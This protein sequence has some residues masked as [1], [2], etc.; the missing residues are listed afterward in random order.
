VNGPKRTEIEAEFERLLSGLCDGTLDDAGR[1]EL[2]RR[3]SQSAADRRTYIEYLDLHAALGRDPVGAA[4]GFE[5]TNGAS[6]PIRFVKASR[7]RFIR[8]VAGLAASAALVALAA[9]A[10]RSLDPATPG[11]E[12]ATESREAT[13]RVSA[14]A[15]LHEIVGE[16]SVQRPTGESVVACDG[17]T[18][19]AGQ[20][21][22][23][24]SDDGFVALGFADGTRLELNGE[25]QLRLA[26]DGRS[27]VLSSGVLRGSVTGGRAGSQMVVSTPQAEIHVSQDTCFSVSAPSA[28]TTEVET[29]SGSVRMVRVADGR[30]AEVPAGSFA[31]A[32]SGEAT[33]SVRPR[34][35]VVNRPLRQL[36][37][38]RARAL[39]FSGDGR[40]LT[41]ASTQ[42]RVVLVL[43]TGAALFPVAEFPESSE[44]VSVSADGSRVMFVGR[45]KRVRRYDMR[46]GAELP[47]IDPASSAN[48]AWAMSG[49]GSVIAAGHCVSGPPDILR[50]RIADAESPAVKV[51]APVRFV[52]VSR[53]G[54]WIAGSMDHARKGPTT[55][56]LAIWSSRDGARLRTITVPDSPLRALMFSPDGSRIAGAC[57]NGSVRV[58]EVET[59]VETAAWD[60]ADGWARPVRS[61]AFS[62]DGTRLAAG[63]SD[64]RVRVCEVLTRRVTLELDCGKRGVSALAFSSDGRTLAVG[65]N[66]GPVTLW[67]APPAPAD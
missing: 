42:Q 63:T 50:I 47:A 38:Q 1:A 29:Q 48:W 25:T 37:F 2:G 6:G 40:V 26:A 65:S 27:V 58:W 11:V 33:L 46:L 23:T 13:A 28:D 18:L 30:S 8:L 34:T 60:A 12:P 64:G 20:V 31:L 66:A 9:L 52:A 32:I 21:V 22:R 57:E 16:V 59:G 45:D 39:A 53:D 17:S 56:R 35:Q 36:D 4:H 67:D 62:P 43:A 51:E 61:L 24:L 19:G 49:D 14:P 54:R 7:G 44:R 3:V 5:S 41:A 55:N 10:Y 15:T